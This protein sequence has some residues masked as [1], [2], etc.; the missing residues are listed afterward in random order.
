MTGALRLLPDIVRLVGRLATDR[1]LGRG[2]RLRLVLLGAYLALPFD[3]IPDFIPVLGQLDDAV[4]VILGVRTVLR[5]AG[6]DLVREHW[7]GP[8]QGLEPLLRG[9]RHR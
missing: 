6:P 2:A 7:P 9:A 4:V 1:T 5:A 8:P 3:L